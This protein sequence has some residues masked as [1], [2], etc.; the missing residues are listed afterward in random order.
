[1]SERE[2]KNASECLRQGDTTTAIRICNDLLAAV[3]DYP[4]A[5]RLLATIQIQSSDFESAIQTLAAMAKL[6]PSDASVIFNLGSAFARLNRMNEASSCFRRAVALQ[7]AS[8]DLQSALALSLRDSGQLTEAISIF[9]KAVQL[10]PDWIVG[11]IRLGDALC[12]ANRFEEAIGVYECAVQIDP[13]A[14]DT[15]LNLS[16]AYHFAGKYDEALMAA[17]KAVEL[18]PNLAQT[19]VYLGN[20]LYDLG[21][22]TEAIGCY[23]RALGLDPQSAVAHRNLGKTLLKTGDFGRGWPEYEWRWLADGKPTPAKREGNILTP[24]IASIGLFV[25]AFFVCPAT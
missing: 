24:A 23:E 5:L 7:P 8:C 25:N 13:N 18:S 20:A 14:T 19:H 2:L 1:M 15:F 3:P 12:T 16:W 11:H 10:R 4:P 17:R 21:N 22:L 6:F 9:Q